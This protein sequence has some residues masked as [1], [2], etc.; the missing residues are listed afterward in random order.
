MK[1]ER[2]MRR[3]RTEIH[4]NKERKEKEMRGKC[5]KENEMESTGK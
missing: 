2:G 4:G 1:R 5:W 3:Y